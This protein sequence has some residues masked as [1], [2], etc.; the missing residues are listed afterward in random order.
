MA[1]TT[2]TPR[3]DPHHG[4]RRPW[5]HLAR[6]ATAT[7]TALAVA[8]ALFV[9]APAVT[10]KSRGG[11]AQLVALADVLAATLVGSLGAVALAGLLRRFSR[12][13]RPTGLVVGA[14]ALMLYGLL[15]ATVAES[16]ASAIWLNVF[17]LGVVAPLV[18]G[19]APSLTQRRTPSS[20]QDPVTDA[21]NT[22]GP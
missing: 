10:V 5:E 11:S 14:A 13:P 8:T 20:V 12:R 15:A 21:G 19:L 9:A 4:Q 16:L 2:T 6:S 18:V 1:L 3:H 17:H 7:A 22:L